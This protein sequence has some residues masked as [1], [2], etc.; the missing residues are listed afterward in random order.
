MAGSGHEELADDAVL[1]RRVRPDQIVDDQ[2]LG[3]PRPSSAAFKDPNLSVDAEP[4]LRSAGLD[5]K[6]SLSKHPGFSLV[7]IT[8][9][10]AR[11]LNQI[12][13]LKPEIDN[14]SH[15]EVIGK[16]TQGTANALRD[17][18]QWIHLEPKC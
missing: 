8:A 14:P 18:S 12:V 17:A 13:E 5:W 7:S 4:I 16:K 1:L 3:Q 9:G 15:T 2:N 6:F 11:S 10:L